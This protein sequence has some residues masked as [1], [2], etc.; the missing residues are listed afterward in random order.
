MNKHLLGNKRTLPLTNEDSNTFEENS[1]TS[2]RLKSEDD[3][4]DY[5]RARMMIL[6]DKNNK[7]QRRIDEMARNWMHKYMFYMNILFNSLHLS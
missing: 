1:S 3:P 5:L 7:L 6:Q 4:H 2:K